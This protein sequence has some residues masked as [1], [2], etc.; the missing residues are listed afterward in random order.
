MVVFP[1]A[2]INLGLNIVKKRS[3]GYHNLE[4][5]FYPIGINDIVEITANDST[6]TGVT[7]TSSGLSVDV[8]T[9][10]NL[11][12]KAYDLLKQDFDLPPVKIH[13]HKLIPMGAGLGGGSADAAFVL[14]ALNN[15]F[16]LQISQTKIVEYAL[17]LG[18][19]CP[20]FIINKPCYAE[21]RGE[22][23]E[24]IQLNLKGYKI[25]LINPGIHISTATAFSKIIPYKPT[26][27][28]K[29]IINNPIETWKDNLKND[30]EFSAFSEYPEIKNI[31][32]YLYSQGAV[33]A[34][35][36]GTGS[37]V[38]GIFR[39]D[40]DEENIQTSIAYYKSWIAL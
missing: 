11:C 17:I 18:S 3:D 25:L 27:S 12:V 20:F 1:N 15:K 35:M 14:Q 5:V 21:G 16:N 8:S 31:K 40:F 38:Y 2:K 33:Y 39:N 32:E 22:V 28:V 30:F 36:T 37:T 9:S 13:L 34:S 26:K 19:D 24:E 10:N 4:T 7:F 6:S 29:E 23:I